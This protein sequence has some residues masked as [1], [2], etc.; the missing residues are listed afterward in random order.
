MGT[1]ERGVTHSGCL[2]SSLSFF[3]FYC[4]G[5]GVE[6]GAWREMSEE[7]REVRGGLEFVRGERREVRRRER[8]V[9]IW[10]VWWRWRMRRKRG[11]GPGFYPFF[12]DRI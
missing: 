6:R 2:S 11:G 5:L 7:E 4:E 9:E 1:T 12:S 3:F 10:V 8:V